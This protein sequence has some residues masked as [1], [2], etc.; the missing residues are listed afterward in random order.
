MAS[1]TGMKVDPSDPNV[2]RLVYNMYRGMLGTYNNKANDIIAALPK[3]MVRE[4]EGIARQLESMIRQSSQLSGGGNTPSP[5]PPSAPISGNGVT[6]NSNSAPSFPAPPPPPPPAPGPL[7]TVRLSTEIPDTRGGAGYEPPAAIQNAMMTKDKKPFTYTPGGLDLSQIRSPRMQRRITRNANA[8]GVG[9]QPQPAGP[10]TSSLAQ[11][12][13]Q[14]PLPPSALA[15]MQ[16]QMPVP[17]FPTAGV[18][19]HPTLAPPPPPPPPGPATVEPPPNPV[20][21]PVQS[22]ESLKPKAQPVSPPVQVQNEPGSIYVPPVT[23]RAQVGSLYIPPI[24]N[25]TSQQ[26]PVV[27]SPQRQQT[28]ASPLPALNKAPTPWMSQ[29]QRNQQQQQ[30]QQ[31]QHRC[32]PSW[33]TREEPQPQHSAGTTHIIPIQVEGRNEPV[34]APQQPQPQPQQ[35]GAVNQ[36]HTRIIP[37]Q[38]EGSPTVMNNT[39]NQAKQQMPAQQQKKPVYVH[40]KFNPPTSPQTPVSPSPVSHN[41]SDNQSEQNSR[42]YQ[43]QQSWGPS[44]GNGGPTQSRSFR[45]LQKITDTDNSEGDTD[46]PLQEYGPPNS[47]GGQYN[48]QGVPLQQLRKL[49]LSEDDRALMNKFKA[50]VP[51]G[52]AVVRDPQSRPVSVHQTPSDGTP[53]VYIPPSE[54]QVPEPRKY[55]GGAIP[56]RS[57]RMLQAMTAPE[58]CATVSSSDGRETPASLSHQDYDWNNSGQWAHYDP[59]YWG[60]EAWWGC[61]PPPTPDILENREQ[62]WAPY[63]AMYAYM[64]EMNAAYGFAPIPYPSMYSSHNFAFPRPVRYRRGNNSDTDEGSG[65]SSTDEMAYFGANSVRGTVPMMNS[66]GGTPMSVHRMPPPPPPAMPSTVVP[67]TSNSNGSLGKVNSYGSKS[68]EKSDN[69][70]NKD[71]KVELINSLK[72]ET[73]VPR[74]PSSVDLDAYETAESDKCSDDE[75]ATTDSDTEVEEDKDNKDGL[76]SGQLQAICSVS[77]NVYVNELGSDEETDDDDDDGDQEKE[78]CVEGEECIPH[79]LSIIYEESEQ[80][81]A[82]SVLRSGRATGRCPT[83]TSSSLTTSEDGD[84]S[85]TLDNGDDESDGDF[86]VLDG[87]SSTVTVRLPLKLKFSRSENDEEVTTVI[88]GDSQVKRQETVDTATPPFTE[89]DEHVKKRDKEPIQEEKEA[90]K[91]KEE[92][93]GCT[94]ISVTLC[95]PKKADLS[96]RVEE[97]RRDMSQYAGKNLIN[98]NNDNVITCT[99]SPTKSGKDTGKLGPKMVGDAPQQT[100]LDEADVYETAESDSDVSVCLSLPLRKRSQRGFGF[101]SISNISEEEDEEV[102]KASSHCE[103]DSSSTTSIQTV[104]LT[105]GSRGRSSGSEIETPATDEGDESSVN[106]LV[107][108]TENCQT[109]ISTPECALENNMKSTGAQDQSTESESDDDE[110]DDDD[111]EEEEESS[112]SGNTTTRRSCINS[113]EVNSKRGRKNFLTSLLNEDM[114]TEK[115]MDNED[116]DSEKSDNS[117][118]EK[119]HDIIQKIYDLCTEPEKVFLKDIKQR[120]AVTSKG[121]DVGFNKEQS[122]ADTTQ[123]LIRNEKEQ[124]TSKPQEESEEDDSGVTSDMSR[125]ISDADT[126]S[127]AGRGEQGHLMKCQRASTHSRLFKLLQDEC[128]KSDD[129]EEEGAAMKSRRENL[130]LPLCNTNV[131]DPDSLSSSS[132]V[133]SPASPTVTDRLVKELVQSL[134][135]RK[136]GRRLK[137]LP[138]AKL[139]AAALR[140]LQ[141][142][143]DPYDTG[144]S[145]DSSGNHAYLMPTQTQGSHHSKNTANYPMPPQEVMYG[146]KYYDYCDYYDSWANAASYYGNDACS[147]FEYDIVPSRAFKLLS[148][149]AQPGG[150][151]S[152][153]INGLWA[154]CPRIPSSKNVPKYLTDDTDK[155]DPGSPSYP[156]PPS[157]SAP[158]S[159]RA[160]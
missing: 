39:S 52:P 38:I 46:A 124:Q 141:E 69:T 76:G 77:D 32:V 151:S 17:V 100:T 21:R 61:Y 105:S 133:A 107:G 79:Q 60:P 118:N 24:N 115:E 64:A 126:E 65:Y 101:E 98:T 125:P 51:R 56:S 54:Q 20:I 11:T 42:Q 154:K 97:W 140:I 43:H 91:E 90:I 26:E 68:S 78:H 159:A 89:E 14:G 67:Q 19:L 135:Q 108:S 134:L 156:A 92:G 72:H 2:K 8:E 146:D 71:V 59:G 10:K 18:Q 27:T 138:L 41:H 137:K 40:N 6:E 49:Q 120:H 36:P 88:V 30:Q 111:E 23:S 58:N 114:T 62:Y 150:F 116:G 85:T 34:Q 22:P 127:E 128:G 147:G 4:D 148:E 130:T 119:E 70:I 13:P 37:I 153:I 117:Q 53:Q 15:A 129:E 31:Q 63:S 103:D 3:E 55:T 121:K 155:T 145:E 96:E 45:V 48:S 12:L 110:D 28:A 16:P 99:N 104:R 75:E 102:G 123:K 157:Q 87:E 44:G 33:V 66:Q 144:S 83:R 74:S 112:E 50:Q 5:G 25:N 81:D 109:E 1:T 113:K 82:E 80:S 106:K 122:D 132:G 9:D 57:F 136:K 86:D 94:D 149:H 131:S 152:G 158:A 47:G 142:D 73:S 93:G 95:F 84:S 143:M 139:H 29:H 7:P 35:Q 160:T